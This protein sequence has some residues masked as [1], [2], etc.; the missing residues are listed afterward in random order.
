MKLE[1]LRS[2]HGNTR[3]IKAFSTCGPKLLL[4]FD[5]LKP[6]KKKK[7]KESENHNRPVNCRIIGTFGVLMDSRQCRL[8][9]VVKVSRK[10]DTALGSM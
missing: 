6:E 1:I 7:K 5:P 3:N 2:V 8:V 4:Y 10:Q 9:P